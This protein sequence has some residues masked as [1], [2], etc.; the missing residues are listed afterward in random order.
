MPKFIVL[1][2]EKIA[3]VRK[4]YE[5]TNVPVRDLAS[6]C[7]LGVTTFLKRVKLWGWKPRNYRMRDYD[8]AAQRDIESIREIAA[9]AIAIAENETL[10]DRVR[11]AVEREIVAIEAVLA[12]VEGAKLRSTDA[13]RAAR[14]L[15]T[16]VKTLR[17]V[18]ALQRDE[19]P[20]Q[21][22]GEGEDEFRDL[23]EFRS[24]LAERLDRLRRSRAAE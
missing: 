3:E 15:A 14:T 22:S 9:P 13:E 6:I 24:E 17:E 23:E 5:G 1:P 11:T 7:G 19:K 21:A 16:L 4:L 18:A 20:E 12:R 2:P 8:A 10:I